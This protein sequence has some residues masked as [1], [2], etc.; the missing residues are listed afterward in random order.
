MSK[1][2]RNGDFE[3][4]AAFLEALDETKYEPASTYVRKAAVAA[5]AAGANIAPQTEDEVE[6]F[7]IEKSPEEGEGESP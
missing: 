7:G 6:W 1:E 3:V 5:L 2:T 4:A